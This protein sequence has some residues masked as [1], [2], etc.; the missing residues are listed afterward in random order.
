ML[1]FLWF[2]ATCEKR[3]KMDLHQQVDSNKTKKDICT[4]K[5]SGQDFG[6]ISNCGDRIEILRANAKK[7]TSH[8]EDMFVMGCASR[9]VLRV[10]PKDATKGSMWLSFSDALI[11]YGSGLGKSDL[12]D[13]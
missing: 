8:R 12:G 1:T 10:K 3:E 11:R 2:G 7:F 6:K 4:K 9:L 13:S 5:K